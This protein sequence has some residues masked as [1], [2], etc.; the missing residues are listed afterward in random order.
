M[1]SDGNVQSIE[2]SAFLHDFHYFARDVIG[3]F[4]LNQGYLFIGMVI[5][6]IIIIL[7]YFIVGRICNKRIDLKLQFLLMFGTIPIILL[8][9]I[10]F[11]QSVYPF[12]RVFSFMGIEMT[13]LFIGVIYLISSLFLIKKATYKNIVSYFLFGTLCIYSLAKCFN[14][15]YNA[16]YYKQD[17]YV[18]EVIRAIELNDNNMEKTKSVLSTDICC[19]YQI[20]FYLISERGYGMNLVENKDNP[21]ILILNKSIRNTSDDWTL[22]TTMEDIPQDWMDNHMK[23]IFENEMY[24]LYEKGSSKDKS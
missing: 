11:I 19:D 15:Y 17:Q 1:L 20:Y 10:L 13:L 2:R 24:Q 16:P 9:V 7:L 18:R 3:S 6:S 4:F 8:P 22:H 23:L 5:I 14:S 21:D 12:A